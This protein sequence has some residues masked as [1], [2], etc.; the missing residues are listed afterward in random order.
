MGLRPGFSAVANSCNVSFWKINMVSLK[1]L[2]FV[3]VV[4][5]LGN[6]GA[7]CAD[8]DF[9]ALFDRDRSALQLVWKHGSPD[10]PILVNIGQLAGNGFLLGPSTSM[11][12]SGPGIQSGPLVPRIQPAGVAG[13][14]IPFVICLLPNAEYAL[15]VDAHS[16]LLPS[17]HNSLAEVRDH[18]WT[19]KISFTGQRAIVADVSG[20]FH[21]EDG[22]SQY[23]RKINTWLGTV[24]YLIKN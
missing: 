6:P 9:R 1:L 4:L 23:G 24:S 13:R 18:S 15:S 7:V 3:V 8:L 20:R 11:Y 17:S 21:P 14:V 12:I 19:I 16:L 5:L 2:T 22:I 10:Q